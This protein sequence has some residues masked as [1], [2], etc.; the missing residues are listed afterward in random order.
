MSFNAIHEY[1][2][3]AKISECTVLKVDNGCFGYV[4]SKW[5]LFL[6]KIIIHH[7]YCSGLFC[8]NITCTVK[9]V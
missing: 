8:Y 7:I 3:L 2:I 5:S 6:N 4:Q 9:P 1:K